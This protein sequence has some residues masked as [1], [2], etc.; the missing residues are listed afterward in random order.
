M[1]VEAFAGGS[2]Q[3]EKPRTASEQHAVFFSAPSMILQDAI[4]FGGK[5]RVLLA[6]PT[7]P[8]DADRVPAD[9]VCRRLHHSV[10]S[11][12]L[13]QDIFGNQSRITKAQDPGRQLPGNVLVVRYQYQRGIAFL[14]GLQ[15]QRHR[16]ALG[17]GVQP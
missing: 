16:I 14:H 17:H 12:R 10:G 4:S 13:L 5:L 3:R 1:F 9:R 15:Q 2:F 11:G 8:D 7:V 6:D